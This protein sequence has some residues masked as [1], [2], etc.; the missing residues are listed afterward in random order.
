MKRDKEAFRIEQD[1]YLIVVTYLLEPRGEA[2]VEITRDGVL[3][4]E[5]LWPSY[6]IWNLQAHARDIVAGLKHDS[7]AG[8]LVAGSTGLGGNVYQ[9]A[10]AR[11]EEQ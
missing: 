10:A 8:L 3:V 9:P 7:D 11:G 5:F 6:K 2:L 1:S 4:K